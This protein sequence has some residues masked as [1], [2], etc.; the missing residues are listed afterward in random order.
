[1][2]KKEIAFLRAGFSPVSQSFL[3]AF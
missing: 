1:M 3:N 2:T